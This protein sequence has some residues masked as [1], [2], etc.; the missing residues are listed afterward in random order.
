[1]SV[2]RRHN[3]QVLLTAKC[4]REEQ[5]QESKT[6]VQKVRTNWQ[7][8]KHKTRKPTQSTK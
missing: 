5:N 7:K 4:Q 3:Q 6:N 1:M 8:V 2:P